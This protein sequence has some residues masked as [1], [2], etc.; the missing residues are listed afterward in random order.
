M[1]V[2]PPA[3]T[4]FTVAD[5]GSSWRETRANAN[6]PAGQ[7]QVDFGPLAWARVLIVD[8]EVR[9]KELDGDS[10]HSDEGRALCRYR[11]VMD[12]RTLCELAAPRAATYAVEIVV[13]N[14]VGR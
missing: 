11:P 4:S 10:S 8:D 7:V 14:F 2:L 12:D 13:R 9:A 5:G 1:P 6:R 3:G